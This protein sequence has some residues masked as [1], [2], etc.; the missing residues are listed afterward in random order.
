MLSRR[1]FTGCRIASL[2]VCAGLLASACS[3]GADDPRASQR[4][5]APAVAAASGTVGVLDD[6]SGGS[7]PAGHDHDHLDTANG[8]PD[9]LI[10]GPQGAVAQFVVECAFTHAAPDD[11]I[12]LP[13]RPGA[14]HLHVFFGATDVD[15][16]STAES[17]AAGGTSCDQ[18]GDTAA[19][20]APALLRDGVSVDPIRSVA[21]YRAGPGVDPTTVVPY[22]F[23]LEMVAGSAAAVEPQPLEVVAWTCG[24]GSRREPA[25]PTCPDSINVRL[26]VTFPDCWNGED[27][28]SA[29]LVSHVSY[30]STGACPATHPVPIPQ[31]QFS[32]EY[33]VSGDLDGLELASGGLHSAHADF[34][35]AWDPDRLEREVRNCLHRR[36]VCGVASS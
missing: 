23:G 3:P 33:P 15:A 34:F 9:R 21:Y 36:V 18:P 1:L 27:L 14:S 11:P 28:A 6:A 29:D 2:T 8:V 32:V 17:L 22:P 26:V 4:D 5:A 24:T 20:W 30:S 16:Y 10:A 7:H 19:Y 12:V 13:G 25:P 31:L 35:N